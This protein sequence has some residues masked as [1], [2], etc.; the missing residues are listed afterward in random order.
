[1]ED[2][3]KI[4]TE[5]EATTELRTSTTTHCETLEE[6][7]TRKST[8]GSEVNTEEKEHLLFESER[9]II[10]KWKTVSL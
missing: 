2:T 3:F 5:I 8:E 1:M 10:Q 9:K 4:E 7:T 6:H